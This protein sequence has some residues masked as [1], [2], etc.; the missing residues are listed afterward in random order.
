MFTRNEWLQKN[1]WFADNASVIYHIESV[2]V[3]SDPENP[4][5]SV[6]LR[7]TGE[8]GSAFIRTTYFVREDGTWKHR[9]GQEEISLFM[10]DASYEEFVRAQE[11]EG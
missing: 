10:P 11:G 1:Q 4:V 2:D 9:F 7:I 3:G 6:V 8:D 5:A